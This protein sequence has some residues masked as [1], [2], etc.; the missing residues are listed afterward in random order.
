MSAEDIHRF[1]GSQTD[2]KRLWLKASRYNFSYMTNWEWAKEYV[3]LKNIVALLGLKP[4][5]KERFN[6]AYLHYIGGIER[7]DRYMNT[8]KSL[9][10]H[11]ILG[12]ETELTSFYRY[13]DEIEKP[14]VENKFR[15]DGELYYQ[16]LFAMIIHYQTNYKVPLTLFRS[17]LPRSE[18]DPTKIPPD[19]VKLSKWSVGQDIRPIILPGDFNA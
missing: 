3:G 18:K 2:I 5:L 4:S 7:H 8:W 10:I 17:E 11:H 13:D 6:T 9:L 12:G 14:R 19:L 16:E 1:C 15:H